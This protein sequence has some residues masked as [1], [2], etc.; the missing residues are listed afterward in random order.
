MCAYELG[1]PLDLIK[2]KA[3]NTLSNAN[4]VTTGGSI[5][6]ELCCKVIIKKQEVV[7]PVSCVAW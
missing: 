1:V 5:T 3:N 7:L 2:V 4:D 6:S